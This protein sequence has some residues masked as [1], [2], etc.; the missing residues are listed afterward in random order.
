MEMHSPIIFIAEHKPAI[1][2]RQ[3]EDTWKGQMWRDIGLQDWILELNITDPPLIN[4]H[5]DKILQ[6]Y[7]AALEQAAAASKRAIGSD[8]K[9]MDIIRAVLEGK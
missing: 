8:R 1:L 4:S 3:A 2:L 9:A 7:P 5:V 6:N